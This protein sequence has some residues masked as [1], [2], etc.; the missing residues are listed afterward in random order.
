MAGIF[1]CY[2]RGDTEG[3]ARALSTELEKCFGEKSVFIDVDS[4]AFGRDFRIALR[5]S[6]ES[7]D[8]F[9]ALIGPSWLNAKDPD[10]RRR[11]DDPKDFVREE[12]GIALRRNIPVTPI[13]LQ[14]AS[15]PSAENLPDDLKELAFRNAFE[16]RHT[17]WHADVRDLL[18]RLGSVLP[19]LS[20][21][22]VS[23]AGGQVEKGHIRRRPHWLNRRNAIGAAGAAAVGA[24]VVAPPIL[25]WASKASKP[26]M[27]TISFDYAAVD[28]NGAQ[29]PMQKAT[30]SVF[31]EPISSDVGVS[32]VTVPDGS[33]VMG[34][35][36]SEPER[37]ANERPQHEVSL[38]TFCMGSSPVTQAQWAAVVANKRVTN[39]RAL[40]PDPS[41]FK[42]GDLPVE[43]I[44]WN[45]AAEFCRRLADLTGRDY[46]LPTEAEWEYA[47]RAGSTGPFSFGPTIITQLANYC[48]VG[49]AVCG[50]ND[51]SSIASDVYDGVTY[52]SGAYGQGPIGIFRGKTT[53]PGTFPPN[54]FGL[55]DMHGNVWEYCQDVA[56]P[57][58]LE[59]HS[60][61]S[62]DLSGGGERILRGGSWSHNPAICRAA[63]RDQIAQ[64]NQGWRG[65]I[66]LRLAC[67]V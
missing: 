26:T 3:Q 60:D 29:L 7:C 22:H 38:R 25:R 23:A 24:A 56:T 44:S 61:G 34:S 62:A 41:F 58:Y 4:I 53:A 33:F 51:G 1:V 30:A 32:M 46:R 35:P 39:V 21:P 16:I 19:A 59:A 15:M 2:R 54:R 66:G 5:E 20:S 45:D 18:E 65:R 14:N 36:K 43:S 55:Y 13:L 63:Y 48:G 6:I 12:I 49:G 31:T 42:A 17:R 27:R 64:D 37:R 57:N 10:G 8:V 47:C 11:L 67:S 40:D 28:E 50:D 9:L 52:H